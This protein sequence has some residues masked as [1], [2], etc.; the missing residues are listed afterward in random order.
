MAEVARSVEIKRHLLPSPGVLFAPQLH[1]KRRQDAIN[2]L[3]AVNHGVVAGAE[4][5]QES[6]IRV[7]N[8]RPAVMDMDAL[9]ATRT[10]ADSAGAVVAGDHPRAQTGKV[11][12]VPD[13]SGVTGE[14]EAFFEVSFPAAAKTPEEGLAGH[15]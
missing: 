1:N 9:T 7:R 3:Q 11:S 4:R 12:L 6:C 5:N 14:A 10:A 2:H 15:I 8:T 13:F